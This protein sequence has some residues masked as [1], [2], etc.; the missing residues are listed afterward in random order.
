MSEFRSSIF[1]WG[2]SSGDG[3]ER[4]MDALPGVVFMADALPEWPMKYL[5]AGSLRLTGYT[6]AELI[7]NAD[8][9][10]GRLTHPDDFTRVMETI[11]GAVTAR[12]MYGVEYR[13]QTRSGEEKWVWEKGHGVY[14]EAGRTLGLEGFITDI[15][16]LKVTEHELQMAKERYEDIFK[17][18]RE[19]IFQTSADGT[20]LNVNPSLARTYGYN[21]PEEM[22]TRLTDIEGQLYVDPHR[23]EE[24]IRLLEQRDAVV[25]F[26]SEVRRHDGSVIWISENARA[27]RDREG[28]LAYYEGS[29]VDISS[30]KRAEEALEKERNMLRTLIDHW[31]DVIYVRSRDGNYLLSNEAHTRSLEMNDP[32]EVEGRKASDFFVPTRAELFSAEDMELMARGESI[33]N[34]EELRNAGTQNEAWVLTSKL[35]LRNSEGEIM[36]LVGITRDITEHKRLEHQLRHSQKMEAVGTLAG[37]VA[38]DFNNILTAILGYSEM[39]VAKSGHDHQLRRDAEEIHAGGLRAAALTQQLLA[40]S[41]K[42]IS[43]PRVVNV[44]ILIGNLQA[45]LRRLIG[46]NIQLLC[47][48]DPDVH[49]VCVDAS[50]IEQVVTNLVVNARDAMPGGGTLIVQTANVRLDETYARQH[51][52]VRAGAYVRLAISDTGTGISPEIIGRIFEPFFTTKEQ[53]KGTG[54]GLATSYGIIKQSGG[55]L[56][57]YSEVGSGT[58][59]NVYIPVTESVVDEAM[60]E[61]V[62]QPPRGSETILLVEDDVSV[63]KFTRRLLTGLDYVVLEAGNGDEALQ[64]ISTRDTEKIDLVVTDVVMPQVGGKRLADVLATVSPETKVIFTSGYNEEAVLLQG[65]LKGEV[66]FLQKPYSPA[67]LAW[68]VRE[69]VDGP[70]VQSRSNN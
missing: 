29:V 7:A 48:F 20:Y 52:E 56:S 19:G 32:A 42:Q 1:S 53:G 46:E 38:H 55:H 13:I 66:A 28:V 2:D 10:Y 6:S 64:L 58:T 43:T 57:V 26:E 67:D 60:T 70:A 25:N 22:M 8:Y 65:I 69:V 62:R 68:K 24:F 40:F 5:S 49:P 45:M 59:F 11:E 21:S 27:V 18:A 31:P 39:I 44:N 50:Q 15:T 4:F 33:L 23:R 51:S 3:L 61:S 30:R 16:S 54:L 63:R 34:R 14:D 41:R 9:S 35:L 17:N 12:E 47:K 36:G 37:G